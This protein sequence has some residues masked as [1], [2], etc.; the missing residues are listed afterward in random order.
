MEKDRRSEPRY[1]VPLMIHFRPILMD[2]KKGT[3][4]LAPALNISKS[5]I[6]FHS[7]RFFELGVILETKI[8]SPLLAKPTI[9]IC[10]V[11]RA[12]PIAPESLI[13]QIAIFVRAGDEKALKEYHD[14]IAWY[15]Q[16]QKLR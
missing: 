9:Y 4:D 10:R 11:H 5:G 2:G 8:V 6:C 3:W 14:L 7:T 13:Y 1:K 12:V 16:A 15:D